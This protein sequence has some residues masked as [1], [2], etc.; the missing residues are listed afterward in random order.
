MRKARLKQY[1]I[2]ESNHKQYLYGK[3][4]DDKRFPNGHLVLTTKI[5]KMDEKH[6]IAITENGTEYILEEEMTHEKFIQLIKNSYVDEDYIRFLL[7]PL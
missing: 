7:S 2:L 6:T 4:Y 3:I 5:D 1:I